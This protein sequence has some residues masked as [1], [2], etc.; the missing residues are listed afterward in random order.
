VSILTTVT[1]VAA[2]IVVEIWLYMNE[3]GHSSL[4][5]WCNTKDSSRIIWSKVYIGI[6]KMS[7]IYSK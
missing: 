1:V 5:F 6:V 7:F 4:W 2:V 3:Y